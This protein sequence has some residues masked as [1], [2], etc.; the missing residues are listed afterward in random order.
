MKFQIKFLYKYNSVSEQD[1][2]GN[3]ERMRRTLLNKTLCATANPHFR[4]LG[5][6]QYG[7]AEKNMM[8]K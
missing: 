4:Q 6:R 1:T 3:H 2:E 7:V 8:L 5:P